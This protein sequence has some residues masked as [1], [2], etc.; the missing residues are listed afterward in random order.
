MSAA[1]ELQ[2]AVEQFL[3]REAELLDYGR[4]EEWVDLF[5]DDCRYRVPIRESRPDNPLGIPDENDIR[6]DHYDDDKN[7]LVIRLN[8]LVSTS[9]HS[10][11]PPSRTRRL[12]TNVRVSRAEDE[13]EVRSNL[14]VFQGRREAAD[15]QFF[16]E[17]RD[18]LR[19]EGDD[20]RIVNR[21]VIL[22]H[23]LLPRAL[24]ILF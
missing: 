14:H 12:V 13:V 2:Y 17:R 15:S 8:R 23:N 24:T 4:F 19:K 5:T 16:A 6:V 18:R 7:G 1:L 20:F 3:F 22:D 10:E 9:A 11:T 21:F